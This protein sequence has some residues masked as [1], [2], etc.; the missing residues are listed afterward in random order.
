MH[1]HKQ[2]MPCETL[3]TN[4][5]QTQPERYQIVFNSR[6]VLLNKRQEADYSPGVVSDALF[7]A[8]IRSRTSDGSISSITSRVFLSA[9]ISSIP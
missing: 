4:V 3:G 9:T 1:N 7:H 2:V 5:T 6:P 8:S